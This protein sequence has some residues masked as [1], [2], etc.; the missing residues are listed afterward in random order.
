V[1]IVREEFGKGN[2]F[3]Q[4]ITYRTT[5]L[6][7]EELLAQFRNNY[8]PR[9]VVTVDMIATG[10]DVKPIEIVMFMRSVKSRGYFEQMKGR[11]VRVMPS[12]DLKRVT[13]DAPAKTHFVI[14]DAVGVTE[15]PLIDNPAP[16][17]RKRS[18]SFSRLME[19]VAWG[20]ADTATISSLAFRLSKLDKTL[21]TD[22]REQVRVLSGGQDFHEIVASLVEASDID[23]QVDRAREMSHLPPD[24]MPDEA[25]IAEAQE[26][27][28]Q[29]AIMP[30]ASNSDLRNALVELQA[31]SEQVIDRI[32]QDEVM[33]AG[34][35]AAATERS[36]AMTR[37]FQAFI[38][39]HRD[40]I[41]ALQMLY[42]QPYGSGLSFRDIRELAALIQ[43][44][45]RSWTIDGLWHAYE[46][47]DR[48]RVR[49]SGQRV[50]TDLVSLVRFAMEQESELEPFR[51][52]VN[53]RFDA[54]LGQQEAGGDGN[55]A[56]NWCQAGSMMD[57]GHG[58]LVT[59]KA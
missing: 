12:D 50:L 45:P 57:D 2:D 7:P 21:T 52:R 48:S 42:N 3:C 1:A 14:I 11:G 43:A 17:E 56:A 25:Q 28:A 6:K 10:T 44:P 20:H 37:D 18:V 46:Q 31:R 26:E 33:E 13:R 34:F 24:A 53:E 36:R 30:L 8:N 51:D 15:D 22:Q 5:G 38:T 29:E 39:E 23:H 19:Q 41:T 49:S 40:E 27:L 16:L 54:W 9:I 4:K 32:S 47:L 55:S 35:S 59:V 58:T